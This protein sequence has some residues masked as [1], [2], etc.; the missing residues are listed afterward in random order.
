MTGAGRVLV[1]ATLVLSSVTHAQGTEASPLDA[2][3]R[4]AERYAACI[5]S[6][7]V[8]CL[9]E[10][11]DFEVWVEFFGFPLGEDT[12]KE[13]LERSRSHYLS[14]DGFHICMKVEE[15]WPPIALDGKLFTI[16]PYFQ[17]GGVEGPPG[18][19]VDGTSYLIGASHNDGESWR[20]VQVLSDPSLPRSRAEVAGVNRVLRGYGDRPAPEITRVE[21]NESPLA[22]SRGNLDSPFCG[23]NRRR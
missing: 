11:T 10:L 1:A 5:M 15:P 23:G 2:I 19:R 13:G 3:R 14:L 7:G 12:W 18:R 22:T 4:D 8:D 21:V 9:V 20:F 16:V 17:T 6:L